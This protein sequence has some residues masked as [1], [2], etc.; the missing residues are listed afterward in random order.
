MLVKDQP[1]TGPYKLERWA[2]GGH[3][4]YQ[5]EVLKLSYYMRPFNCIDYDEIRNELIYFFKH[6]RFSTKAKRIAT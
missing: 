1:I 3:K 2:S 4:I 5:Y 6:K